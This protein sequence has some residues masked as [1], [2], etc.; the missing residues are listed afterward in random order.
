GGRVQRDPA[1]PGLHR[2]HLERPEQG[3]AA[4]T[5][6][7]QAVHLFRLSAA[8]QSPGPNA[9]GAP[10]E[11]RAAAACRNFPCHLR[12]VWGTLQSEI[13]T[14]HGNA[15]TGLNTEGLYLY[16]SG[17]PAPDCS[18]GPCIGHQAAGA[19]VALGH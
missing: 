19:D 16:Y 2:P 6:A 18:D 15:A 14:G 4:P 1:P 10:P 12:E 17:C 9:G 13:T 3:R 7:A 5:A 8:P 11:R